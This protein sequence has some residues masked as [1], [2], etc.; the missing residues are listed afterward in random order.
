MQHSTVK[1]ILQE[2]ATAYAANQNRLDLVIL[3]RKG[4]QLK[5]V[6]NLGEML[7]LSMKELAALLPVTER[8]LQRRKSGTRLSR[9]VSEQVILLAEL[10]E[11]GVEVFG[12]IDSFRQWLREP[13]T[14]LGGQHPLG[15]L[16][17]A[18]GIQLITDQ[19]GKLQYGVYS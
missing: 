7:N 13:N 16:D 9:S 5:A 2:P 19:L 10:T 12:A 17:T 11:K 18:I 1:N 3:S 15:L 6:K 14:A 4:I 8:T